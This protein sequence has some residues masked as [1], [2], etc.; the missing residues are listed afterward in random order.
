MDFNFSFEPAE[1]RQWCTKLWPLPKRMTPELAVFLGFLTGD[2]LIES[3]G[4]FL[5]LLTHEVEMVEVLKSLFEDLGWTP[6]VRELKPVGMTR[7]IGYELKLNS[8]Q[9]CSFLRYC[10]VK[11]GARSKDVPSW[12]RDSSDEC[13]SA[14]LRGLFEADGSARGELVLVTYS[15][16]LQKGSAEMLRELGIEV[17]T[18]KNK[19]YVKR[20]SRK[21]FE[22]IV[23]FLSGRKSSEL[24]LLNASKRRVVR[25]GVN[26]AYA[27]ARRNDADPALSSG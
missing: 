4:R 2:G 15:E 3:H 14:F 7:E 20:G 27:K 17:T 21:K 16:A 5:V 12:V 26:G 9:V 24:E 1:R 25:T 22:E 23:G 6:I 19:V 18:P 8:V 10:G 11:T 13:R